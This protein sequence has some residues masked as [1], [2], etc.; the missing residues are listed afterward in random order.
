M[1]TTAL[2]AQTN[3]Q[4]L[5]RIADLSSTI[6]VPLGVGFLAL[7]VFVYLFRSLEWGGA[8]FNLAAL[9]VMLILYVP[10]TGVLLVGVQLNFGEIP[11]RLVVGLASVGL[12]GSLSS[13]LLTARS[14]HHR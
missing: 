14:P 2:T 8:Q 9:L 7:G 3:T 10:L 11:V 13:G 12:G 5:E 4:D 6:G 1:M